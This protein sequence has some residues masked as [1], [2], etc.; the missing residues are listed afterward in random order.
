MASKRSSVVHQAQALQAGFLQLPRKKPKRLPQPN[1]LSSKDGD[2]FSHYVAKDLRLKR[3]FSPN[4]VNRSSVPLGKQI[5]DKDGP[6][7]AKR[8]CPN[9]DSVVGKISETVEVRNENVCNSNG[10]VKCD[11][12]RR[13]N[14][15]SEEPVLSTPPDAEVWAGDFVAPS[16]NGCPRSSNGGG[17]GDTCAKDGSGIDSVTRTGS[18]NISI[19]LNFSFLA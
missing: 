9:E 6:I 7:T 11:E 15:K 10:Y 12:D 19:K 4:L 5:S 16:L 2:K 17:L 3:V 13:C 18:V 1:Q 8:T 14:E